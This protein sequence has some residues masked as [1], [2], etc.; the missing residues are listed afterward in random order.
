VNAK[1]EENKA[2][3]RRFYDAWNS[4]R[5]DAFD[6][7]IATNVVRHCEATPGLNARSLDDV[8]EFLR[9]DTAVFPDSVQTIQLLLAEGD[10]V[11]AWSTYEGTQKGPMG[12]FPP[13]DRKARFDFGAVFR[14]ESGKIAEWWVTWDNTTILRAL[15]HLPD[16]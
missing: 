11:A 8:K 13:S 10:L 9:L 15:G 1:T 5:A 14:M 6:E 7:V 3:I 16:G 12:P 4:R 2:V